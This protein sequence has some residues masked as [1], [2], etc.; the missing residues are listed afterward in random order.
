MVS[1]A[2]SSL[3]YNILGYPPPPV[4]GVVDDDAVVGVVAVVVGVAV[5]VGDAVA[6]G[7]GPLGVGTD[8]V[9][10]TGVLGVALSNKQSPPVVSF[11][12]LGKPLKSGKFP[13]VGEV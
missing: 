7:V 12:D 1:L 8:T 10:V 4:A 11:F 2:T 6:V 5:G 13:T 3:A 9:V